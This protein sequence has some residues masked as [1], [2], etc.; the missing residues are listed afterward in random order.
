MN[1]NAV[2]GQLVEYRNKQV[3][4]AFQCLSAAVLTRYLKL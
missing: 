1:T 2:G 3:F 4:W